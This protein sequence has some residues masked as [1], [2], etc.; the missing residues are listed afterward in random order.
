MNRRDFYFGQK[1]KESELD[2]AFQ[3]VEDAF[4]SF[5][6]GFAYVG[7]ALGAEVTENAVPNLTV[8]VS[9]PAIIYD[10]LQQH[11]AWSPTQDVNCA[12][13][14]LGA[15]TAVSGGG[16]EKWLSIFAEFRT[17]ES[18]PRIDKAGSPVNHVITESFRLN[19][20]QGAEAPAGTAVRPALRGDQ[21]L[22]A[23]VKLVT[24]QTQILNA[25]ISTTRT[26]VTY[27]LTG[28]PNAVA[29]RGLKPVLQEFL[30]IL[31]AF[32]ASSI[33]VPA[34]SDSPLSLSSASITAVFTQL[35]A[36]LNDEAALL[37]RTGGNTFTTGPQTVDTDSAIIPL[38]DTT[39]VSTDHPG[40]SGNAWKL[41]LRF[42]TG[43]SFGDAMVRAYAG[44]GQ[45][46]LGCFC[47]TV[48][49]RF[50]PTVGANG[51]W[52]ADDDTADAF[53]IAWSNSSLVVRMKDTTTGTWADSAWDN[54]ATAGK[55]NV[56][57]G[58]EYAYAAGKTRKIVVPL[59]GY[60]S[61]WAYPSNDTLLLAANAGDLH[62]IGLQVPDGSTITRLRAIVDPISAAMTM[63]LIRR[64]SMNFGTPSAG[65][66]S[67]LST[68]TS[69]G[70]SLQTLDTGAISHTV[71]RD[72]QDY[73][74][75]FEAGTTNDAIY[76]LEVEIT[77]QG[78]RGHA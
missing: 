12:I 37:D 64:T 19:V 38:L 76:A 52:E 29:E 13:D 46:L 6:E 30:D 4:Q 51:E 28:S 67:V 7:I 42:T 50:D 69:S 48:N 40:E 11:I 73:M 65:S 49:A 58:G 15:S 8:D 43:G 16:N 31:N 60:G 47:F 62:T 5:L 54:T 10:Q 71:D 33:T 63:Q 53:Q 32:T 61:G 72:T 55:G 24:S 26:E 21:I 1:V 36:H 74:V 78:Y 41:V 18:D 14:E 39:K 59:V 44:G 2:A 9:G 35:L 22:L 66:V 25:D 56:V 45:T 23:D 27:R 3:D 68:V 34:I 70:G 57:L 77:D 75:R 20:A 17:V